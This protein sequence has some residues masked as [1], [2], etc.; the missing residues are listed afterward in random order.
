[1]PRSAR[2]IPRDVMPSCVRRRRYVSPLAEYSV[3]ISQPPARISGT[4][5]VGDRILLEYL[6]IELSLRRP[7]GQPGGADDSRS[8][9]ET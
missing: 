3:I 8:G 6:I 2:S 4:V 7:K 9:G 1:M 5:S